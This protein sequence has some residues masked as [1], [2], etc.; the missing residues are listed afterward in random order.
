[1]YFATPLPSAL[2]LRYAQITV[3]IR[4]VCP[5]LRTGGQ[6]DE[7]G[8][9]GGTCIN[10]GRRSKRVG[11]CM[12]PST[13]PTNLDPEL[14]SAKIK[15]ASAATPI[16]TPFHAPFRPSSDSPRRPRPLRLDSHRAR[17]PGTRM[18]FGHKEVIYIIWLQGSG[19]YIIWLRTAFRLRC[20]TRTDT[21]VNPQT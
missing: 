12:D 17:S 4:N 16:H 3:G 1:M 2:G 15:S 11:L 21:A 8:R 5:T 18:L 20:T 9:G 6:G 13:W 10:R 7:G 19:V 14:G